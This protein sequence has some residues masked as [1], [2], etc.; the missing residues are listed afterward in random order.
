MNRNIWI[1]LAAGVLLSVLGFYF[2][3]RNVPLERLIQSM[4]GIHYSW[5]A[6]GAAVGLFSFGVRA[7]R[8]QLILGASRRL[9]FMS[10]YHPL[11]IAFMINTVM[12]GRIGEIAR[13]VIIKKQENVPFTLGVTTVIAERIFDM[14]TLVALF[15]WVM[16]FVQIDP[17][18]E[19]T[20]RKWQL[21]REALETIAHGLSR[22][23]AAATVLLAALSLPVVQRFLTSLVLGT[24]RR[25]LKNHPSAARKFEEKVSTP[26]VRGIEH[27]GAG[28]SMIRRPLRLMLCLGYSLVIWLMQAFAL[29]LASFAFPA[30]NLGFSQVMVVFVI[31]CFFIILPSVPGFWGIWEAGSVFGLA[32]FGVGK[33]NAAGFSLVSH[34]MLLFPVMVAGLIS[35]VAT[36]VNILSVRRSGYDRQGSP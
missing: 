32:L 29:H 33:D 36:G 1:S 21:D 20:F 24:P 23:C 15:A 16:A 2:A 4:A 18:L 27:M 5:L 35:A 11:M 19:I 14:I 7:L 31:I 25:L 8:W 34:A 13:P 9:P 30:I 3:F 22:V 12:P 6:A 28:L 26:I 17:D 10:V